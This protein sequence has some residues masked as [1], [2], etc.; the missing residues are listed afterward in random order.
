MTAY[1]KNLHRPLMDTYDAHFS[2]YWEKKKKKRNG[3]SK[4]EGLHSVYGQHILI[5]W[6]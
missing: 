2:W 4:E 3:T 6:N 5:R 1:W